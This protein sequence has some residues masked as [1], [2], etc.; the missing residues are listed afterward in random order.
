MFSSLFL[1]A[2]ETGQIEASLHIC[3]SCGC[4]NDDVS[5]YVQEQRA[6]SSAA[7]AASSPPNPKDENLPY[8]VQKRYQVL[9]K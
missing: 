3:I 7:R 6:P 9:K 5:I 2:R 1:S 8:F 4:L